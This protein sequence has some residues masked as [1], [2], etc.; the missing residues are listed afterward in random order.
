MFCPKCGKPDQ[1]PETYCRQCGEY[2]HD[3]EKAVKKVTTPEEHLKANSVLS[4]MTVVASLILSTLLFLIFKNQTDTHPIIY[5]TA[6]FLIAIAAW[7]IQT[8]WRTLLIKKHFKKR[9]NNE[10]STW[11][12][13]LEKQIESRYLE[14][15]PTNELLPEAD[16]KDY[17]PASVVE[18]TTRKLRSKK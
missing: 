18:K 13:E 6:G 4:A 1:S 7:Q 8:F 12:D 15:K 9:K 10:K 3:Y 16:F 14:S 2:L 5:V 17:V 11:G